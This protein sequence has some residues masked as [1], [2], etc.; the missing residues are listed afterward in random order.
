[1]PA[2]GPAVDGNQEAFALPDH[3]L[4]VDGVL[5]DW[6]DSADTSIV[7]E[8]MIKAHG[9]PSVEV[10]QGLVRRIEE[11]GCQVTL[12]QVQARYDWMNDR[13]LAAQAR[14]AVAVAAG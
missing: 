4:M 14:K 13:V 7:Y 1:M 11:S 10:F 2:R 8:C 9:Q 5:T 3:Q 6:T 12:P